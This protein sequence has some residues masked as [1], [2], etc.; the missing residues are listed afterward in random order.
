MTV[1]TCNDTLHESRNM[2]PFST[3]G[4]TVKLDKIAK[5][6]FCEAHNKLRLFIFQHCLLLPLD[7]G[8]HPQHWLLLDRVVQQ[9]VLQGEGQE[10]P[11]V[12]HVPGVLT[13][14][15]IRSNLQGMERLGCEKTGIKSIC[16]HFFSESN[17]ILLL[18]LNHLLR[19]RMETNFAYT[20]PVR[21]VLSYRYI[22]IV[23][24]IFKIRSMYF[25]FSL[26]ALFWMK[27]FTL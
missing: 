20:F 12:S 6:C 14:W 19:F 26:Y 7:Y 23:D 24:E 25:N 4:L 21:L 15:N 16:C 5:I 11:D 22:V 17:W 3:L 1:V 13:I 9:I 2:G 10:D 8:S 27:T 18:W